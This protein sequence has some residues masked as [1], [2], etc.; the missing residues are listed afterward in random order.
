M[1]ICETF[2][3]IHF[4]PFCK[5]I[6]YELL[7][8]ANFIW[9]FS[10]ILRVPCDFSKEW[11]YPNKLGDLKGGYGLFRP[12]LVRSWKTAEISTGLSKFLPCSQN[13][14]FL[15]KLAILMKIEGAMWLFKG[16]GVSQQVGGFIGWV[17]VVPTPACQILK[18]R[19]NFYEPL[20]IFAMNRKCIRKENL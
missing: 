14:D 13:V 18:N 10:H 17:W 6:P 19:R 20:E 9:A 2:L 5:G 11:A 12:P 3:K 7:V 4:Q 8:N 1:S 15:W 16:M